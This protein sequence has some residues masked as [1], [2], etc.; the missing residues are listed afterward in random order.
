MQNRYAGDIGDFAKYGLLR[1]IREGKR[2]G[3]AW[4]LNPDRG[5]AGDGRHIEYLDDPD[6]FR[7]L[8]PELFDILGDLV[9]DHRRVATLEQSGILRRRGLRR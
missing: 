5:P 3:I 8:D 1:A 7:S 4:Y 9:P 2:L 6:R